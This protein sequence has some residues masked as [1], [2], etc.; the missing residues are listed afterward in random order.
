[1][2]KIK[3]KESGIQ[4]ETYLLDRFRLSSSSRFGRLLLGFGG[5]L[6]RIFDLY[7]ST[8]FDTA[9]QSSL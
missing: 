9:L 7:K 4:K 1:M 8:R 5:H 2:R 6:V 3:Y